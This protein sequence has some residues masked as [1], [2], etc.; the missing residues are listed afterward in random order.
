MTNRFALAAAAAAVAASFA[1]APAD[2]ETLYGLSSFVSNTNQRL[3][4]IDSDTRTITSSVDIAGTGTTA[5]AISSIDVRPATGEL[6]GIGLNSNQLLT[7]NP[8]SGMTTLVGAPQAVSG[9]IDFNPTVDRIRL[10]GRSSNTNYRINP[11]TGVAIVDGTLAYSAGDVNAGNAPD[12]RAVGYTNSVAGATQTTLYDIDV[13]ADVLA[14]QTPANAGTLQTVGSLGVNLANGPFGSGFAGFDISG[15]TGV[16]YLVNGVPIG[17]VRDLYTVDL[18][19]GAATL[20]GTINGFTGQGTIADI[21]VVTA[22]P[23]PASLALLGLS[24][25]LLRRRRA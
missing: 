9:A 18:G 20:Q 25:L 14:T 22:V 23:E 2:A 3:F 13:S 16:A 5:G 15:A 8:T 7:I 12:V 17:G 11:D 4:T 10:I 19:T 1:A 21:A 6:Y 24:G